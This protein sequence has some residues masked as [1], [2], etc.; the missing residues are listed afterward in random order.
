MARSPGEHPG[1]D[2]RD[3]DPGGG[4]RILGRRAH[5]QR[6]TVA[7]IQHAGGA[8]VYDWQWKNGHLRRSGKPRWPAWLIKQI[9]TD[10]FY[11]VKQVEFAGDRRDRV[12]DNLMARLGRLGDLERLNLR[13]CRSVTDAELAHLRGLTG[14]RDLDLTFTRVTAPA[15]NHWRA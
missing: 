12:N 2:D 10:F 6:D 7:A 5:D 14:L 11:R 15:L 8:V 1:I 13:G 3:L 4:A 9:G